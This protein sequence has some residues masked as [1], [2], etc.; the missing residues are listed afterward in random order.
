MSDSCGDTMVES[1]RKDLKLVSPARP[2]PGKNAGEDPEELYSLVSAVSKKN[3]GLDFRG[4]VVW[5]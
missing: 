4:F 3:E 5:G 2:F 1:L